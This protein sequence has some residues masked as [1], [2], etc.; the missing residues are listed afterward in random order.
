MKNEKRAGFTLLETLAMLVCLFV[1]V[2]LSFAL[3]RKAN[4]P[5][6]DLSAPALVPAAVVEE[7]M[8]VETGDV[9]PDG[10]KLPAET[11]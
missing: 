6:Q 3:W 5:P 10:E 1:L 7:G 8:K 9:K 4:R 11:P 2:W